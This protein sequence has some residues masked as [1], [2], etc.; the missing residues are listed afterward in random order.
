[1]ADLLTDPRPRHPAKVEQAD[2]TVAKIMGRDQRDACGGAGPR[3]RRPQAIPRDLLEHSPVRVAI[4]AGAEREDVLGRL[5]AGAVLCQR[6]AIHARGSLDSP[7]PVQ[8]EVRMYATVRNYP[9][10]PELA[11]ALVS[12][13]ADVKGL[14]SGIEGFKAYYLVRTADGAVSISVYDNEAGA[15]ESTRAAADWIRENLPE[16]GVSAPQVSAG[17]V[18]ISA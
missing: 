12:N 3:E 11:D 8:Q 15:S 7:S 4:I 9:A 10:S 1:V 18:V 16:L 14:V 5:E 13:A 2:A 6:V 17:E